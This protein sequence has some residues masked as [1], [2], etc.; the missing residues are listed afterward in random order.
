MLFLM[1]H[2]HGIVFQLEMLAVTKNHSRHFKFALTT[3]QRNNRYRQISETKGVFI[4]SIL[5]YV[6]KWLSV[7]TYVI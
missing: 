5:E 7:G 3:R 4:I 2:F 1:I 6:R